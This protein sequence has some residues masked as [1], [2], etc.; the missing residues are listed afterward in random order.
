MKRVLAIGLI[1]AAVILAWGCGQSKGEAAS[2]PA[3][4]H[5]ESP[6][7]P[8]AHKDGEPHTHADAGGG[9]G[10][11]TIALSPEA[12]ANIGLTVEAAEVRRIERTL[13]LNATLEVA[14]DQEAFVS[15][16]VQG[17]VT[18]VRANVGDRV[19]RGQPLVLLQS[20]QIAEA[21]PVV[22]VPSPLDGVVLERTVTVGETIDPAK[23]LF[24]IGNLTSMLAGAEVF[25]A[26]LALVR[27]GQVARVRVLPYPERVF[28]GRV[29]RLSN[30]IDPVRRTLRIWIE[31]PNTADLKLKP[32]M[33]AQV[34][35]VV[36]SSGAAVTVPNEAVQVNGPERFVFVQ[37]GE[38]F[39]RQNVI[40]G[41]RDDRYTAIKGG[42]VEGDEVVVRGAVELATVAS[43]PA[44]GVMQDES[45]P[46]SH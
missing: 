4:I 29:V 45:K 25:E 18:E 3:A 40:L 33:F 16:R 46:H 9:E 5:D 31:V 6:G 7:G 12:R 41:E 27:R 19:D 13:T 10:T 28:T 14:P 38:A 8:D 43:Q 35:L 34:N 2:P 21:P 1:A 30:A 39:L 15:S 11:G 20:L 44:A 23:S 36:S 37:N 17:K 32:Q 22:A 26:D 24:H 42:L